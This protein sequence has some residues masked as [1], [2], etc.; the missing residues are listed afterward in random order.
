MNSWYNNSLK[1][2]CYQCFFKKL[3]N[4]Y[5]N[6]NFQSFFWKYQKSSI[7]FQELFIRA[8]PCLH[9]SVWISYQMHL[10]A[11]RQFC[12]LQT[13]NVMLINLNYFR[14]PTC[15]RHDN[16][17]LMTDKVMMIQATFDF[18]I[19][20]R[21]N[22]DKLMTDK[23]M[24]IQTTFDLQPCLRHN[25]DKSGKP[26]RRASWYCCS[27]RCYLLSIIGWIKPE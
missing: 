26:S 6:N 5:R 23:V 18:Q 21:H 8:T 12:Y 9:S 10:L 24:I 25:N 2:D 16:D 4:Y 27:R 14:F 15:L 19:C 17:N 11:L 7:G 22:N 13:C 3:V 1:R 20:L